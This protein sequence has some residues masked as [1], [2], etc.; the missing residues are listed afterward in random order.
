MLCCMRCLLFLRLLPLLRTLLPS[1]PIP[2]IS[3]PSFRPPRP[4]SYGPALGRGGPMP[5]TVAPG[6]LAASHG[7]N[8]ER[9]SAGRYSSRVGRNLTRERRH[10]PW[11]GSKQ[12]G[13][14]DRR[15]SMPVNL[16]EVCQLSP[17]VTFAE[18]AAGIAAS[19][20]RPEKCADPWANF[21]GI[22]RED[23]RD[24]DG[25]RSNLMCSESTRSLAQDSGSSPETAQ[26]R[27]FQPVQHCSRAESRG[28][29]DPAMMTAESYCQD[30]REIAIR[31]L[32]EDRRA[33]EHRSCD[34]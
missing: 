4:D 14:R 8:D 33:R 5:T 1:R 13:F 11:L 19:G 27:P 2:P 22:G 26:L 15:I 3:D 9:T 31:A 32:A 20:D 25:P 28:R 24:H 34:H 6:L 10:W 29:S 17:G 16:G 23:Y 7:H 12:S 21:P 30:A 18:F